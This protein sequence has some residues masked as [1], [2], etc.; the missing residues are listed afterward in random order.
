M[1]PGSPMKR[2]LFLGLLLTVSTLSF[3][4]PNGERPPISKETR[5]QL[6]RLMNA[7]YAWVT[8]GAYGIEASAVTTATILLAVIGVGRLRRKDVVAGPSG[9]Q[10]E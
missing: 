7:E 4:A 8:G 1:E 6:I 3:A 10:P 5:M 9:I 2:G